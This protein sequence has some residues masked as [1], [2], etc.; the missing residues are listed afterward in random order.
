MAW[1]SS[2][3]R[4]GKRAC[5]ELSGLL[6]PEK[7]EEGGP[8]KAAEDEDD[9]DEEGDA[10]AFQFPD[11]AVEESDRPTPRRKGEAAAAPAPA[12]PGSPRGGRDAPS[13]PLPLGSGGRAPAPSRGA[14][15]RAR[16]AAAR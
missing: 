8:K 3:G 6:L 10:P 15:D 5:L 2:R 11:V 1:R 9:S 16:A 4:S 12:F 13:Q 14:E 7:A